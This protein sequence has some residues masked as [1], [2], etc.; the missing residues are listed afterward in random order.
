MKNLNS[1]PQNHTLKCIRGYPVFRLID[2]STPHGCFRFIFAEF[3]FTFHLEWNWSVTL[4]TL[5]R[6]TPVPAPIFRVTRA[7]AWYL[8]PRVIANL[9]Q[10][11]PNFENT[12]LDTLSLVRGRDINTVG[13]E[14]LHHNWAGAPQRR[15][16]GQGWYYFVAITK[17]CDLGCSP[18]GSLLLFY[19]HLILWWTVNW[20]L[21][22][23]LHFICYLWHSQD[24]CRWQGSWIKVGTSHLYKPQDYFITSFHVIT[25]EQN[26]DI[27]MIASRHHRC[28]WSGFF[29][30]S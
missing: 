28:G 19:F 6:T 13:G 16:H 8:Q 5:T 21:D 29:N 26:W 18:N 11:S 10:R 1:E 30:F 22:S 3:Y 2:H 7:A 14:H 27:S 4:D 12:L 24:C 17:F 20:T 15:T 9:F 25:T 23:Q